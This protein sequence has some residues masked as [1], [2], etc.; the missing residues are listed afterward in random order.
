MVLFEMSFQA[1]F[2]S[3]AL[4]A[5]ITLIGLFTCVLPH[6]VH[7]V[8]PLGKTAVAYRTLVRHLGPMNGFVL[9]ELLVRR[10]EL[11]AH[12]TRHLPIF[13]TVELPDVLLQGRLHKFLL[14]EFTL[15][16]FATTVHQPVVTAVARQREHLAALFAEHIPVGPF[17]VMAI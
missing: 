11:A 9:V 10:E 4:C 8:C 13:T 1:D 2:V 3:E 7:H 14:A 15:S 17:A 12:G 5:V 16:L 6:V